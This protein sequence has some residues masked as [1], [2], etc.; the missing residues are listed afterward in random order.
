MQR[1]LDLDL[2]AFVYGTAHFRDSDSPRLDAEEFPAWELS[3]LT[4]FLETKC[5]LDGPRPGFAVEHHGELFF[6]WRDAI[7]A[8]VLVPPFHVTHIDAHADLGLGDAGY[9]HLLTELLAA[10]VDQRRDPRV[11]DAGLGDGNYLAFAIA[12]Q[13][14][15]A[16]DYV[17]GGR[18]GDLNDDTTHTGRPGDLLVYLFENFD[19]NSRTM[20]L[21][22]LEPQN[23]RENL[24]S[25][26]QL[27]PLALEPP[28][29][30][31]W[32]VIQQYHAT[33]PFDLV[34][35][36]RSP[37]FTPDTADVLYDA[38]RETFIDEQALRS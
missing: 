8:S 14:I 23:L 32:E 10:P 12:N 22:L 4:A 15:S 21:P 26:D 9:V 3:E 20:R 7:D 11:G 5:L 13:W 29:A 35:V 36:A 31:G 19:L 30:F 33:A 34:C 18:H 16:L 38:I 2:D 24:L 37:G 6:R 27:R 17:I 28:V 1:I 25:T